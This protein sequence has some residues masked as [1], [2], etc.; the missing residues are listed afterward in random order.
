GAAYDLIQDSAQTLS[1][2]TTLLYGNWSSYVDRHGEEP[3]PA[4]AWSDTLSPTLGVRYRF[5]RMSS[6]LDFSY[7]PTPVPL[8]RGRTNYV[9]NDRVSGALGADYLLTLWGTDLTL[10][11]QVQVHRLV[12]RHQAKL[13]TPTQPDGAVL[14]PERVKDELPDDAQKSGEPVDGAEGLQ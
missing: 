9:D 3:T 11:A 1:L 14:A 10:G 4:Y 2:V 6:A 13:R 5:G 12:P 8:Q 7:V